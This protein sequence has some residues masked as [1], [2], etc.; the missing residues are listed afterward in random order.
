MT[1]DDYPIADDDILVPEGGLRVWRGQEGSFSRGVRGRT[2]P[3]NGEEVRRLAERIGHAREQL[4]AACGKDASSTLFVPIWRRC[5]A[6]GW[7]QI[8]EAYALLNAADEADLVRRTA[9]RCGPR[10]ICDRGLP[11]TFLTAYP[12][13][14]AQPVVRNR[15]GNCL[16]LVRLLRELPDLGDLLPRYRWHSR[17]RLGFHYW[18]RTPLVLYRSHVDAMLFKHI[19]KAVRG[20]VSCDLARRNEP[21][22][23]WA[24]EYQGGIEAMTASQLPSLGA[25]RLRVQSTL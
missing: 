4:M 16:S 12:S 24:E 6:H 25:G 7:E 2:R 15:E 19:A 20:E 5:V 3:S 13:R 11:R 18:A 22:R 21:L 9:E 14:R 23:Y 1:E 8:P 17:R 10:G